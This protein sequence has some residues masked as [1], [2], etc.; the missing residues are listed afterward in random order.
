VAT[1]NLVAGVSATSRRPAIRRIHLNDLVDALR[2]GYADFRANPTHL[3][4]LGLVYPVMGL[5]FGRMASGSD[6]LP[7]L[8]PLI[9]G[10]ALIGPLAS[11]GLYEL[12]RRRERSLPVSVRNAFDV[13]A[14]PRILA[15]LLLGLVFV[16][17]F[18]AWLAAAQVIYDTTMPAGSAT[19]ISDMIRNVLTTAIVALSIGA[20]SFPLLVDRNIGT[21]PVDQALIAA[22]T[23][24]AATLANPVAIAAWGLIV[25]ASLAISALT[26][27][28]GLAVLMPILGHA[29][30]HLYRKLVVT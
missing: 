29:T 25:A 10:F 3:I 14:S 24:V 7:L 26:L 11:V 22:R 13:F 1:Q 2:E 18:V 23:S 6:S 12:S 17:I 15:I 4:F 19:S 9:G 27:L 28:V 21:W 20:V 5:V 16:A 8:Y 30:W